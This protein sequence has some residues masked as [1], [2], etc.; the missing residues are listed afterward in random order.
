MMRAWPVLRDDLYFVFWMVMMMTL[1][2]ITCYIK[3][4]LFIIKNI[5]IS[6]FI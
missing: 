5:S 1:K 3:M 2:H 4:G 6:L